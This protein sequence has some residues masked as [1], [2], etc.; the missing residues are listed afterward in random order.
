MGKY[1]FANR[2]AKA[3]KGI[4]SVTDE[5][6]VKCLEREEITVL[7][8]IGESARDVVATYVV[9]T[10]KTSEESDEDD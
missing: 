6:N 4:V 3:H 8:T 2:L 1:E 10:P 7:K 9:V 5:K